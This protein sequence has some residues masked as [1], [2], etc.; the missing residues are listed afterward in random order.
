MGM[1]GVYCDMKSVCG[2]GLKSLLNR[3]LGE[4]PAI[5]VRKAKKTKRSECRK[6]GHDSCDAKICERLISPQ[7]VFNSTFFPENLYYP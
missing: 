3:E 7:L 4:K 6:K 2:A 5:G 1:C